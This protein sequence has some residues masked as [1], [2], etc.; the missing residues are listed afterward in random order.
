[1]EDLSSKGSYTVS[2]AILERLRDTF[3]C[4]FADDNATRQTIM[5]TWD[6]LGILIDTHTAVGK[7]VLDA[8]APE[9]RQ[10]I[11]LATASPYKFSADVLCALGKKT[12]GLDG[13]SCMD[14]LERITKT[15]APTQLSGL[16]SAPELHPNVCDR[17]EMSAFV[18][19]ACARIFA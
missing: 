5:R 4:G 7:A 12:E 10:R 13:F 15:S 3:A 19:D 6:D 18:E 14:E 2:K 16:R 17:D 1:M 9:G 11:C 8:R